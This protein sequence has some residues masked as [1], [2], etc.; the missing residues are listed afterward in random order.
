MGITEHI[1]TENYGSF[2]V[3]VKDSLDKFEGADF[4]YDNS[5]LKLFPQKDPNNSFLV[6]NLSIFIFSWNFEIAQIWV[7]WFQ[8]CQYYFQIPAKKH[9]SHAFLIPNLRIFI[10][11]LNF[12]TRKIQAQWF[13]I[14]HYFFQIPVQ[15]T[16]IRHVWSKISKQGFFLSQI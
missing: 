12:G 14:S 15:K 9:P 2:T 16:Q 8:I 7:C 4:K 1:G 13:Q 10:F 3:S 5:F 11:P 6:L